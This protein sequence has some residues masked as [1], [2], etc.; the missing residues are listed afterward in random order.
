MHKEDHEKYMLRAIELA[1]RAGK[2]VQSNPL[3]GAVLVYQD[4]I[5]GE[6]YHQVYGQAHAEVNCIHSVLD[7]D[8]AYI[9][10]STIYV[11][12]EP[13]F[14]YG[15]TP[16]CVDLI[17]KH[18]IP[19]VVIGLEDP[20]DKVDG[21][22]IQKLREHNVKVTLNVC[23]TACRKLIAPFLKGVEH[24]LPWVICKWAVSKHGYMGAKDE[25]IW[26]SGAL[27]KI[28]THR[29]RS[30]IDAIL[31]G[32]G[33]A[34]LDNPKLNT[35]QVDGDNPRRV[36]LDRNNRIPDKHHLL[37]DELETIIITEKKR[38]LAENKLQ[39]IFDFDAD[40]F[41][42][43]LL[44]LLYQQ[45]IYRLLVEG[46]GQTLKSILK[47]SLWDEAHVIET[48]HPLDHGVKGPNL[49]ARLKKEWL[50]G[51]DIIK[52]IERAPQ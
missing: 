14:H 11:T 41:W 6:G 4:R 7:K 46:G 8:K 10:E 34:I 52:V 39:I 33:T 44:H 1:Q 16:P 37:S 45:G 32:T 26:L 48:N 3:V 49:T 17:L 20:F 42:Q 50:I 19:H 30:Q 13:C 12:L 40:D 31:V 15:K 38:E 18:K 27:T 29:Q 22:S 51:N 21:K 23:A 2:D 36:V 35:R 25:Q 9:S 5:I 43:R 28:Y 47:T 24:Q